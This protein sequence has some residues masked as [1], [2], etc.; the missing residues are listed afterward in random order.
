[1]SDDWAWYAAVAVAVVGLGG[2]YTM[3]VLKMV[4]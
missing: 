3:L 2:L 1:M 4:H